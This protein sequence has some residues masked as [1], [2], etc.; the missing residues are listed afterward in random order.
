MD[1]HGAS[2]G[3]RRRFRRAGRV[4]PRSD[5]LPPAASSLVNAG[6]LGKGV[7]TSMRDGRG[8]NI[9]IFPVEFATIPLIFELVVE[10]SLTRLK[11]WQLLGSL[12]NQGE[13]GVPISSSVKL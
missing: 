4:D 1:D 6:A 8:A 11:A 13:I 9:P 12:R 5:G 3:G 7:R 10:N 2:R